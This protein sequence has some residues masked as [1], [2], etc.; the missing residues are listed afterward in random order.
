MSYF[1][2]AAGIFLTSDPSIGV[3]FQLWPDSIEDAKSVNWAGVEVIGRSEPIQTYHSSSAQQFSFTLMFAA[4]V[5]SADEG[6][7]K[8]VKEKVDFLKSL[9]YPVKV[10][11]GYTTYPPTVW[12]VVGNLINSRC[13]ANSVRASWTGPWAMKDEQVADEQPSG[14]EFVGSEPTFRTESFID[15]PIMASVQITLST[16]HESPLDFDS[17]RTGGDYARRGSSGG[18]SSGLGF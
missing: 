4:S 5:D 11:A 15:L 17:V 7:P 10:K 16:V 8:A 12:L 2:S 1:D 6:T 13:I 18:F 3:R 9:T 14:F